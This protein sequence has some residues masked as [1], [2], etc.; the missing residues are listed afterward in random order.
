MITHQFCVPTDARAFRLGCAGAETPVIRWLNF[1][2]NT[3]NGAFA[4]LEQR[5]LTRSDERLIT[6]GPRSSKG[7]SPSITSAR[8]RSIGTGSFACHFNFGIGGRISNLSSVVLRVVAG[9][10]VFGVH[11]ATFI[12]G[13]EEEIANFEAVLQVKTVARLKKFFLRRILSLL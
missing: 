7:F 1:A 8:R 10:I 6:V 4:N 12:V 3:A 5:R 9:G 2:P 11:G 13:E